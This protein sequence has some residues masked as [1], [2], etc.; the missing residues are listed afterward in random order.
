MSSKKRKYQWDGKF[1]NL[2]QEDLRSNTNKLERDI[3]HKEKKLK[4]ST[5]FDSEFWSQNADVARLYQDRAAMRSRL[6]FLEAVEAKR[7]EE[8]EE[9]T[10]QKYYAQYL[11]YKQK[12]KIAE[13]Q[14]VRLRERFLHIRDNF[15]RLFISSKVGFNVNTTGVGSR[16]TEDQSEFV[17]RMMEVYC[18]GA[19]SKAR[20][21][22][23]LQ[24]WQHS[25]LCKAAHLY[26]WS[27]VDFM[28]SIFG[29]GSREEIFL[30]CNGLF[31]HE[32]VEKALERGWL[33][34]VPDVDIEPSDP[35][36]PLDDLFERT[37]RLKSWEKQ[38]VKNYKIVILD[39]QHKEVTKDLFI[40]DG[41]N[42]LLDL[43]QR[44]LVFLTDFRPRARYIWW[45]FLAAILK[46]GWQQKASKM[47]NVVTLEVRKANQYWGTR[48]R[49]V[50]KN[51]LLGF[52]EELGQDVESILENSID[53]EQEE[54]ANP[55]G[56]VVV[57]NEVIFRS[58]VHG[59]DSDED[60][61]F[62]EDEDSDEDEDE[63]DKNEDEDEE[64]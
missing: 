14:A 21:D 51:M 33:A 43:H 53:E 41:I 39:P 45:T 8:W 31:L 40:I 64:Y 54:E 55:Q 34:I 59:E 28:D 9:E 37:E 11:A 16:T 7:L 42:N 5:S 30:P 38:A 63:E 22:P 4:P 10:A 57:A 24:C 36:R 49:Y 35:L 20:W 2:S 44:K 56:V 1:A 46:T 47:A 48:G 25:R 13:N 23:V 12:E 29:Q 61:D 32:D 26:P 62:D 6:S 3:D 19:V 50:K 15:T 27:Q 18:P 17:K 58:Q 52:V 60:E